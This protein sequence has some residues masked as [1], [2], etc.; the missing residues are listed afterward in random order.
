MVEM[1]GRVCNLLQVWLIG[2][3]TAKLEDI[4]RRLAALEATK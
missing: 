3:E 1:S 2:H 4:E